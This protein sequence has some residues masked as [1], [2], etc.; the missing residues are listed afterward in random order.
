MGDELKVS[1]SIFRQLVGAA[2]PLGIFPHP[3][4]LRAFGFHTYFLPV[5]NA[6][7]AGD[8]IAL[9]LAI[10]SP[11]PREWFRRYGLHTVLKEKCPVVLWRNLVYKT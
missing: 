1:R 2:I 4:L 7:K 11:Q 5:I 6:I 3:I 9:D 10:D 8:A